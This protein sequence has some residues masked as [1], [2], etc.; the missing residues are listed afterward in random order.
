M[1]IDIWHV[2]RGNQIEFNEC[3][4]HFSKYIMTYL[5]IIDTSKYNL[6]F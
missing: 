3:S 4:V 2:S 5:E 1:N 6:Y